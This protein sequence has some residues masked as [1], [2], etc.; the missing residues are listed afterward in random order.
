MT[1]TQT[2]PPRMDALSAFAAL[3]SLADLMPDRVAHA[4]AG[5]ASM[6]QYTTPDGAGFAVAFLPLAYVP[7]VVAVLDR[8]SHRSVRAEEIPVGAKR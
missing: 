8:G 4:A 1:D 3:S 5:I 2:K 7:Q 6:E